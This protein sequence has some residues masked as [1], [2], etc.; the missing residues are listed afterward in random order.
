MNTIFCEKGSHKAR[1]C[2]PELSERQFQCLM[3]Y[4]LGVSYRDIASKMACNYQSVQNS[5]SRMLVK[6]SVESIP[7]LRIV[8]FLRIIMLQSVT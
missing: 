8:F 5:M 6:F 2:F 3:L 1:E 7:E 4:S